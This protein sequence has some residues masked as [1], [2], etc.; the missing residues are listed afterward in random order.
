MTAHL[1]SRARGSVGSFFGALGALTFLTTTAFADVAPPNV[2]DTVGEACNT[3]G[4]SFDQP[5]TCQD[6]TCSRL[7]P[8]DGGSIDYDCMLCL[9]GGGSGGSS[10]TGGSSTGGGAS[11]SGGTSAGTGASTGGSTTT[12]SSSSKK[13]DSGCNLSAPAS[14]GGLAG[15]MLLAGLGAL[16]WG[17]RRSS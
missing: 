1:G 14:Q 12:T 8:E 9:E 17:R 15:L 13:D 6:T 3:A 5:G 11:T 7:N 10:A 4:P 16:V 2:C